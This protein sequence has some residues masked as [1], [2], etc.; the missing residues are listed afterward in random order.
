[1]KNLTRILA[2][3]LVLAMAVGMLAGCGGDQPS[4]GNNDPVQNPEN[5]GNEQPGGNTTT[6]A[7]DTTTKAPE[8]KKG[9][10]STLNSTY[11]VIAL[12]A[13]LGFAF[14]AKKREEN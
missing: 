6:K 5:P 14:V 9:C 11:A 3:L 2:L 1:M 13:V 4:A 12:V 8:E 10:G 7:P